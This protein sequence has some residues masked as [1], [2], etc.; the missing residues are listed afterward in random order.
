[1]RKLYIYLLTS[2]LVSI[3][4][5]GWLIDLFSEQTF[6]TENHFGWQSTLASGAAKQVARQSLGQRASFIETLS[7]DY[8]LEISYKKGDTLAVPSELKV[9]MLQS[10]GLILEDQ[11]GFYLLKTNQKL[12]PDYLEL[13]LA[14]PPEQKDND[15]FLTLLFYT[16]VC[17]FMWFIL[18]PLAKR[19]S[20]LTDA[21]KQFASGN[22]SAR[23]ATDKFTYIKD[24][25]LTFNRMASQIEKLL[26]ENKLL[27]SSLSH[28]IRTPVACLRFGLDAALDEGD[29]NK[30]Y[31]L[32]NRM[33]KDL[34]QMEDML[35]SYLSFATLEQKAH[36]LK[37][38]QTS[39]TDYFLALIE[40]V[41]PKLQGAGLKVE[42]EI[43]SSL[44]ITADLHWLARAVTNL[45]S[46]AADFATMTILVRVQSDEQHVYIHIEDDGPGI[47]PQNWH[48]V[49][50]PFFQEQ[51]HRNRA[52]KSYGLGLA[53]VAKVVDWHHGKVSVSQ[54]EVL[55][56][57]KFTLILP[58]K[59]Q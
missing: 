45:L 59:A 25:E 1:M 5:L 40:Q 37:F 9:Q 42:H 50:S 21:A 29:I 28:D 19:L 3:V 23:I 57:A 24:V 10:K 56:G 31:S 13:R 48:K 6:E 20:I 52:Q 18:S 22:F 2:A 55:R 4:V 46:N 51:S 7:A 44:S 14:K 35:A 12:L 54:S 39:A 34:D 38:E 16:G 47:A 41:A 15:A 17:T 11:Q 53:I 27:A 8:E 33:E 36:L 32:L 30:I 26:A 49:F 58:C 43:E